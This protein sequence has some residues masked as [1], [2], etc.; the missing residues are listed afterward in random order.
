MNS[1]FEV[2]KR[3]LWVLVQL[4]VLIGLICCN[5]WLIYTNFTAL[6]VSFELA[7]YDGTPVGEDLLTGPIW[8]SLGLYELTQAHMFA[9]AIAFFVGLLSAVVFHHIYISIRLLLEKRE[10]AKNGD[11]ASLE[12]ANMAII[13]H[14]V[15]LGLVL[16]PLIPVAY[17]DLQLF[18]FRTAAPILGM[19]D[20]ALAMKDWP[21]LMQQHGDLFAMS[22]ARFGGWAYIFLVAGAGLSVELW[23]NYVREALV[24]LGTAFEAWQAYITGTENAEAAQPQ[25]AQ[26]QQ[27]AQAAPDAAQTVQDA[28]ATA[29]NST[30]QAANSGEQTTGERSRTA[31]ENAGQ[32]AENV[33]WPERETVKP[34]FTSTA[35]DDTD[36]EVTVYGGS[37]GEKVKFSVAAADPEN[38]YIDEMR[39]VWK[40]T[41]REDIN[42]GEPAAAAA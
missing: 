10:Y 12:Q 35:A 34:N 2:I 14:L 23:L 26:T 33:E 4:A 37:Q 32:G 38:Y 21:L 8:E 11:T 9:A 28:T 19:E 30:G 5:A 6:K 29:D 20:N 17:W 39:R 24:R 40:R 42:E 22:L 25:T 16:I 18:R 27:A 13:R 31:A 7:K 3:T 1:F 41:F 36:E 15:M